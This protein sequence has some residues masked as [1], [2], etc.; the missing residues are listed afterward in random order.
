LSFG[1]ILRNIIS[2]WAGYA[3][4]LLVGFFLAPLVVHRL[5]TAGY[6]VWTLVVSLTGY[7][8]LLDLGLRS[9]VVRFV[10]RHVAENDHQK[11]NTTLSSALAMLVGAGLL[12]LAVTIVLNLTF[13]MFAVDPQYRYEARAALLVT[14]LNVSLILPLS[15]FSAILP[16]LERYDVMNT[17]T[18]CGA[19]VRALLVVT[20][21]KLGYGIIALALVSFAMST[22][23]YATMAICAKVLYPPL[24]VTWRSVDVASCR[25]LFGFGLFRFVWIV[26][27][28][29]I[30]YTDSVV[31]GLFVNASAI[32]TYAIAGSLINY[33]R[34]IVSLA[35]DTLFPAATRLDTRR[36]QAGLR[37]IYVVGTRLGLL[38]GLSLCLGYICFGK[39]FIYLWMGDKYTGSAAILLVLTIAQF[40]SMSQYMSALILLGTGRHRLLA[41]VALGEAFA[42]LFLSIIL[43][44]RMGVIGVAWGTVIPQLI[45]TGVVL[46]YFTL[47]S[48]EMGPAHY[49]RR[50][51]ARPVM[52]AVP[53]AL[54]SYG[55]AHSAGLP[56]WHRFV[57]YVTVQC[58]LFAVLSYWICLS[59]AERTTVRRTVA[60]ILC[61]RRNP[62]SEVPPSGEPRGAAAS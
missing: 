45:S 50:A 19:M 33:G 60:S 21:L 11:V 54:V 14:G 57:A 6:G 56:S 20:V 51:Y 9:S 35:T 31:I 62:T 27:N 15:V 61:R 7:C 44:Q 22:G 39:M 46:P 28:Q 43:V 48:L 4:T 41:F 38:M 17:V 24:R 16:S 53:V 8:G 1:R 49:V 23:E 34:N 55:L 10:V 32:T 36:D 5:G 58:L 59:Q 37:E 18:V 30:F 2:S 47:R 26:A 29:L 12:A 52:C 3:A 25:E 40:V 13:G 42:N